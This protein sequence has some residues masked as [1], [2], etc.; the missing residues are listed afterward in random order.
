MNYKPLDVNLALPEYL[1]VGPLPTPT[2]MPTILPP[3]KPLIIQHSYDAPSGMVFIFDRES[4]IKNE[5]KL[6]GLIKFESLGKI[7]IT[8]ESHTFHDK[9]IRHFRIFGGE[10]VTSSH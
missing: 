7:S 1:H 6:T 10:G 2:Y 9:F 5:I 8:Q 3:V 4:H